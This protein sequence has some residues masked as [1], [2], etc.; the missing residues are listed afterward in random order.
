MTDTNWI[1]FTGAASS[2]KSTIVAKLATSGFAV[3]N[4]LVREYINEVYKGKMEMSE[5]P[6]DSPSFQATLLKKNRSGTPIESKVFH[7]F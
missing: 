6:W 3:K 1:I 7:N 5:I 2:G 4:E